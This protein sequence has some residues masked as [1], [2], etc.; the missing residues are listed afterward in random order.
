VRRITEVFEE[1]FVEQLKAM[2][3]EAEQDEIDYDLALT[4]YPAQ[5]EDGSMGLNMGISVS[6]STRSVVITDHVLITGLVGDPFAPDAT[7]AINVRELLDGLRKRK[8]ETA[9]VSNGGLIVPGRV[10]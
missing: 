6:M 7:L 1:R 8:A 9:S 3:T 2:L 5:Q 10:N 4:P